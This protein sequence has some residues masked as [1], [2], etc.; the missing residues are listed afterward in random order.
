MALRPIAYVQQ[1]GLEK[2]TNAFGITSMFMGL[3]AAISVPILGSMIEQTGNYVG[4]F[5]VAGFSLLFAGLVLFLLP[6]VGRI[7]KKR[8]DVTKIVV[9]E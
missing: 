4:T 7:E 8:A 1:L 5:V 3:S 9:D 2:L 6:V